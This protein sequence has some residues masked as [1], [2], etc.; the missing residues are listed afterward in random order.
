M[1]PVLGY[2]LLRPAL[3]SGLHQYV[4]IPDY[5]RAI[6]RYRFAGQLGADEGARV[7]FYRLIKLQ[8]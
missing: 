3:L 7:S 5:K 6:S 2:H 8:A 4:E 1:R